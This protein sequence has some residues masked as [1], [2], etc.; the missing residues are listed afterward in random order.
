MPPDEMDGGNKEMQEPLSSPVP[1][2]PLTRKI[3]TQPSRPMPAI[4]LPGLFFF[5]S[6]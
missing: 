1:A 2:G 5:K 6:I 3:G 4:S